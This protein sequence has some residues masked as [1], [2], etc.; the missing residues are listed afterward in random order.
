MVSLVFQIEKHWV[1]DTLDM[2]ILAINSKDLP[3][4]LKMYQ[5]IKIIH[6]IL[7]NMPFMIVKS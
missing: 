7:R 4:C 1:S 5:F 2:P 3:L 6:K